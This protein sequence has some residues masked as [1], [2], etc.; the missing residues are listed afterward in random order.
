VSTPENP[1]VSGQA[2]FPPSDDPQQSQVTATAPDPNNP[3]W[4][5]LQGFLTWFA[6]VVLLWL[7][8]NL[9]A[10]PYIAT[11]Y[12]GIPGPT[13]EVL[14]S[15]RTLI[16]IFLAGT[17]PAH[18]LTLLLAW[19]VAS[20]FGKISWRKSLGFSW[21]ENFGIWKSVGLAILLFVLAML[22]I[23]NFGGQDTELERILRS[24]RAAALITAFVATATAPLAEEVIY[25][26]VLYAPLQRAV[27]PF[28]AVAL[29]TSVFAALHVLL[30]WPNVAAITAISLLS[31][32]L[33]TVRAR[34]GRLLPCFIIHLVFN[35]IQ[36]IIIVVDP[37]LRILFEAVRK[38]AATG[39]VHFF[40]TPF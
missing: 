4:G 8:P 36:S 25:R 12:Q 16:L 37:Y 31:L 17:L 13:R 18:A 2:N 27:G 32:V 21:P 6:S 28:L 9:F 39:I 20:R 38:D 22:I 14:L 1:E 7:I 24:S 34:T 40:F 10:L 30:Y 15:D 5:L 26:G 35:G 33:T 29:V 3:P 23:Y 11:H 19:A